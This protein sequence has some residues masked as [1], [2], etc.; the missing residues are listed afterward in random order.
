MKYVKKPI[1]V[2]AKQIPQFKGQ[3][4]KDFFTWLDELDPNKKVTLAVADIMCNITLK[5]QTLEGVME[6]S[7]GDYLIK[8]GPDEFWFNKKHL[9]EERYEPFDENN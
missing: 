4:A 1:P 6:A 3:A 7:T 5:I 9:F 2:E 8:G